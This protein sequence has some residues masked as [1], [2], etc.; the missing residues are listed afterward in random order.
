[1]IIITEIKKAKKNYIV[2]LSDGRSLSL[3]PDTVF[4]FSLSDGQE[5]D[6]TQ[7]RE[8]MIFNDETAAN[9]A[10]AAF[11][12]YSDRTEK[13]LRD[14]LAAKGFDRAVIDRTV[15][16]F[17]EYEYI[18]D[19]EYARRFSTE[20]AVKFGPKVIRAKLLQRGISGEMASRFA[21]DASED[22]ERSARQLVEKLQYK[23]RELPAYEKKR[24]LYTTLMQKGYEWGAVS[25]LIKTDDE[26]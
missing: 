20:L 4:H 23:Y 8:I 6:E 13:Q 10:A 22:Q 25:H 3:L 7:L 15:M 17:K 24:K 14:K 1:M 2:S 5:I 21:K 12:S 26:D 11:V 18:N 19:E 16:K 9:E